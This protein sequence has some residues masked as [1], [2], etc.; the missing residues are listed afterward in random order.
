MGWKEDAK[1]DAEGIRRAAWQDILPVDPV[2]IARW[3]GI[4]VLEAELDRD[5]AGAL[6]KQSG[7]DPTILLNA[8]DSPNRQRF[9]CAHEL[10][11]FARRSDQP[12]VYEYVDRRN[13]LSAMGQDEEEMYANAFAANLLMPEDHVRRFHER[14]M[15][16][17]EMSLRFSVSREAIVNRLKNLG[18]A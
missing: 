2:L 4:N 15:N 16:D 6:V 7:Q 10:G 11:H 9:T 13:T 14:G 1:R 12:D 3:L 5:V 17:L 18:L 8:V